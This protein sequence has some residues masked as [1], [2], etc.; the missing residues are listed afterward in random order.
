MIF[1]LV[2]MF[3]SKEERNY[4]KIFKLLVRKFLKNLKKNFLCIEIVLFKG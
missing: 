3:Y 1:N 4:M 2:G